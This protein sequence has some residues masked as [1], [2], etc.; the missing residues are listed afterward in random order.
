MS[1]LGWSVLVF[2][3]YVVALLAYGARGARGGGIPATLA[4]FAAGRSGLGALPIGFVTA[5][6]LASTATFAINPGFVYRHGISALLA[7]TLPVAA[8]IAA[9]F[10]LLADRF[11]ETSLGPDGAPRLLTLPQWIGERFGSS[12][13]R[14]LFSALTIGLFSYVVLVVVGSAYV[15]AQM[16]GIPVGAAAAGLVLVVVASTLAGGSA[17]HAAINVIQGALLAV[18]ALVLGGTALVSLLSAGG[19]SLETAVAADPSL[20]APFRADAALFGDPAAVLLFPLV[21]G[22]ALGCQP[23]VLAKALYARDR[24]G[25]AAR[26]GIATAAIF[27]AISVG[28][29]LVGLAARADLGPGLAQDRV[30]AT[31][32]AGTFPGPVAALLALALVVAGTSTLD[33][34]L[35]ALGT[36]FAHDLA[37]PLLARGAASAAALDRRVLVSS[38]GAAAVFG[39][40]AAL[41]A[42]DPPPLVWVTG[43]LGVYALVAAACPAV[44]AGCLGASRP[45]ARF[46]AA[47]AVIGPL[48][49]VSLY[50]SGLS[51]NPNATLAAGVLAGGA[52][53]GAGRLAAA[54]LPA[55]A[56]LAPAALAV[57]A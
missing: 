47:A 2:S 5:A 15:V 54:R 6:C 56:T 16:L 14:T 38:R 49:H 50:A 57:E 55:R 17:A 23:H 12:R 28:A 25:A 41:A 48:V 10:V 19:A 9:A 24:R 39:G 40:L 20:L 34:L 11:R 4:S 53:V 32:V 26:A 30:A 37:R 42:I 3:A 1:T 52:I 51:P 29:L 18:A 31:W 13:L 45:G 21:V 44:I 36:T 46:V 43:A 33:G 8:G 35:L 27:V 22:F 7:F